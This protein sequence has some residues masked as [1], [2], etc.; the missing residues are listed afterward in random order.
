[1]DWCVMS[2][3]PLVRQRR[4]DPIVAG[5]HG[6]VGFRKVVLGSVAG[7]MVRKSHPAREVGEHAE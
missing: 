5:P 1:M 7:E 4:I 2:P 3:C 6:R